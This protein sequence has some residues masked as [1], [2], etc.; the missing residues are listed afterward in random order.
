MFSFYIVFYVHA[1]DVK[2]NHKSIRVNMLRPN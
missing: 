1:I 2:V